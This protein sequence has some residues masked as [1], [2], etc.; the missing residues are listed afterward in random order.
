MIQ[1]R[2]LGSIVSAIVLLQKELY[3]YLMYGVIRK[4]CRKKLH[5]G[6]KRGKPCVRKQS[7]RLQVCKVEVQSGDKKVVPKHVGNHSER[8]FGTTLECNLR[9]LLSNDVFKLFFTVTWCYG[10][11][12]YAN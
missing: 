11:R 12:I 2:G 3:A 5:I 4:A 1:G 9:H 10:S 7:M 6:E 8:Y